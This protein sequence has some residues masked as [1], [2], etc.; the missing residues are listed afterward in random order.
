MTTL[1]KIFKLDDL[2]LQ[3]VKNVN[4]V[5]LDDD[6]HGLAS[7]TLDT[8]YEANHENPTLEDLEKIAKTIL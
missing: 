1:E 2:A 8:W 4:A 3:A 5:I 6:L 7:Q